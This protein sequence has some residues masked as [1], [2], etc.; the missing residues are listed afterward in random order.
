MTYDC[1]GMVGGDRVIPLPIY[2]LAAGVYKFTVYGKAKY[3]PF[4]GQFDLQVGN[5]LP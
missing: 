1:G 5:L 2:G 3:P 4:T